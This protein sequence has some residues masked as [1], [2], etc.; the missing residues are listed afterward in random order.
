MRDG[1]ISIV[2]ADEESAHQA[3]ALRD[4]LPQLRSVMVI[5]PHW[6]PEGWQPAGA[7]P[8]DPAVLPWE[9]VLAESEEALAGDRAIESDLA[10]ILYTSGSTGTPKGVMISHRASL[11]FCSWAA[12]CAG[13]R[14]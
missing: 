13:P 2:L 8:A 14:A 5:G 12:A 4:T 11:T 7:R 1:G 6:G 10:Y 9:T 3:A